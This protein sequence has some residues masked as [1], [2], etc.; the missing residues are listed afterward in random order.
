MTLVWKE[1][2]QL[3][4]ELLKELAKESD[5]D[6]PVP[7][8]TELIYCLTR[9]W[10]DR[11]NPMPRTSKTT[12]MFAIGTKLGE[13][14]LQGLRTEIAGEC[15]GIYYHVDFLTVDGRLGE[16]KSTRYSPNKP[17]EN[18]STGWHKQ[19]LSYMKVRDTLEA[20]Y[21]AVF[22]TPAEFKTW[23]VAAQQADVDSNW[24]WMQARRV[25]Y[26]GHI[27]AGTMP[28]P[29]Q[30]CERWE[31]KGCQYSLI[32]EAEMAM[33]PQIEEPEEVRKDRVTRDMALD[34]GDPTL[35]GQPV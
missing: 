32:C 9:S 6:L 13:V 29:Y 24:T 21:S 8:V 26:M 17:P 3:A 2:P 16:L 31:C 28:T 10:L 33:R 30:H 35:E 25:I 1:N 20:V 4:D 23:E 27:E 5:R 18:W 12:V 7:T 22:L 11:N 34:A 15:E 14:M 19:L